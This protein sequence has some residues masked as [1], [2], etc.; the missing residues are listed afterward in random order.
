[1]NRI[2]PSLIAA[3]ILMAATN[4]S[5]GDDAHRIK[6]RAIAQL[7]RRYR[8]ARLMASRARL[9]SGPASEQAAISNAAEV[10]A[11]NSLQSMKAVLWP[12]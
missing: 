6:R 9:R 4:V 11:W 10:E 7:Y 12:G 8:K 2:P 1:M 3:Q 5:D